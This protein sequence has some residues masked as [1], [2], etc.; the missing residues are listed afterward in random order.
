MNGD[1]RRVLVYGNCQ[2]GWL[3]RA[4][5]Q[6]SVVSAQF[7]IIYLSDY[8]ERPPDHPINDPGFLATC[9]VVVWQTASGCKAPWFVAGIPASTRQIRYPTL[10]LK[11]LWPTYAVDPRNVHEEKFPWGRYP[12][13]DRLVMKLLAEN[14]PLADLPQRYVDFDLNRLVNLDRFTEMSLAELRFNDRQSDV[15][16][17]PF[18]ESTFRQ[19]K[20]FGTVNHPTFAILHQ[21]YTGVASLLLD[22]P[23]ADAAALPP[24]A[25]DVLGEEETPLHPQIISHFKLTWAQAGLRWRYRTAFLTLEE[26]LRAYAAFTPI[27]L[28]TPPSLWLA[29]AQQA[30]ALHDLPEARRLLL[31]ATA[32]FPAIPEFLHYLGTVLARHQQPVEAE[33]VLRYALGQ[34]PRH[35][36]L[37]CE[38]AT[39]MSQ[40]NFPAEAERLFRECL[41][42][43]PNHKEARRALILLAARPRPGPSA[44]SAPPQ[45]TRRANPPPP[46]TRAIPG[47][48]EC[49]VLRYTSA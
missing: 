41:R 6:H 36:G 35:A 10:W 20:L 38:L 29:R 49:N 8:L 9:A 46:R 26:Y 37:H 42:L 22:Q 5:Q 18:I 21:I 4:L 48:I 11:L 1:R 17:T 24:N 7:E 14:V 45:P 12:Y 19:R 28:G 16:I 39:L 23:L 32:A 44:L 15:A 43:D 2:G 25:A 3:A 47:E 40:Q 13:G 30:V 27:P 31:E 34:H 33:K